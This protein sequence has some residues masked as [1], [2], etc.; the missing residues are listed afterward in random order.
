M[1]SVAFRQWG[2][3]LHLVNEGI[4]LSGKNGHR[5]GT[6]F[7]RLM[8]AWLLAQAF[9]YR[10]AHELA[11]HAMSSAREGFPIF[12]GL[13]ISGVCLTGLGEFQRASECFNQVLERTKRGPYHLDWIFHLPLY[14]GLA[15]L[16][17]AQGTPKEAHEWANRLLEMAATSNERTYMALAHQLLAEAAYAEGDRQTASQRIDKAF[18]VIQRRELP[19]AAWRVNATAAKLS[20]EKGDHV[21]YDRYSANSASIL[22]L[23]AGS[24]T[25]D[26][27][28]RESILKHVGVRNASAG[29]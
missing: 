4:S 7:F 17:L 16:H 22:S 3:A 23:L 18:S 6:A 28:M 10:E 1:G 15:D 5:T 11:Q 13:I 29:S 19:L 20:A 2:D 27:P 21:L 8:K 26:E 24:I 25:E 14:L 12:L 9:Q